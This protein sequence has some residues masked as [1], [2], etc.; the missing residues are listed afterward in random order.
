[1]AEINPKAPVSKADLLAAIDKLPYHARN[2]LASRIG[3][4]QK[5]SSELSKL[6]QDLRTVR[7][8][9]VSAPFLFRDFEA[10]FHRAPMRSRRYFTANVF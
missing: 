2:N 6:L 8:V 4:A 10:V 3:Q 1:M 7:L 9:A 5:G